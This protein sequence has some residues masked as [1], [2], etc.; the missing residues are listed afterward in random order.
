MVTGNTQL[1]LAYPEKWSSVTTIL[2]TAVGQEA[3]ECLDSADI[4]KELIT[5]PDRL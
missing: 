1:N 4:R 5:L 2:K 3:V